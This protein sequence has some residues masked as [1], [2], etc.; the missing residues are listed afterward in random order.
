MPSRTDLG[1][2]RVGGRISEIGSRGV[3]VS[4]S[5]RREGRGG[6]CEPLRGPRRERNFASVSRAEAPGVNVRVEESRRESA[7]DAV[8]LACFVV[9]VKALMIHT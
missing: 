5:V 7:D 9:C 2:R 8:H 6:G 1:G 4:D 3:R